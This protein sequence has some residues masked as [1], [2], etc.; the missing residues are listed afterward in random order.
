MYII[1]AP[2]LSCHYVVSWTELVTYLIERCGAD[3]ATASGMWAENAA[4]LLSKR[5][6]VLLKQI[7]V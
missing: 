3:P 4:A 5:G 6:W 1:A 2:D 7:G